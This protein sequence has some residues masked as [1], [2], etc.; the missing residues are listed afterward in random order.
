MYFRNGIRNSF[1]AQYVYAHKEFVLATEA[2]STDI[3][4]TYI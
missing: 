4:Q 2:S 1:T 3:V